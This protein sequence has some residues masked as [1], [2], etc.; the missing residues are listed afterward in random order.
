MISSVLTLA[1]PAE[2][3]KEEDGDI[4][5]SASC[6]RTEREDVFS[7]FL[8]VGGKYVTNKALHVFYL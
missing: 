2:I 8:K 7:A 4:E 3:G 1:S 6:V 5:L